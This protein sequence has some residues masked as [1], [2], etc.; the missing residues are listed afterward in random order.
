MKVFREPM[1]KRAVRR[2]ALRAIA[3]V[4]ETNNWDPRDN[5][6]LLV[7]RE[8]MTYCRDLSG[9]GAVTVIDAGAN[10]GDYVD[11]VCSEASAIGAPVSVHAFEPA[12]SSHALLRAR[13]GGKPNVRINQVALSDSDGEGLIFSD[14]E[15]SPLASMYRRDLRAIDIDL[16][17]SERVRVARLDAYVR[18]TALEHIHL[19]KIDVEGSEFGVL[20]GAGDFLNPGFIDFIQFEYGG[21][22]LDAG[23]PLKAFFSLLE[24]KGFVLGKLMSGGLR[25]AK[26]GSWMDNYLYANYVAISPTAFKRLA[27]RG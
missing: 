18:E 11:M 26:Y 14:T 19:L 3:W 4:E 2:L 24:P 20:K 23:V 7:L 10:R 1:L 27:H 8:A 15:G 6:E 17:R 16:D 22:N 9:D 13:H 5:G 21:T 25:V 12:A